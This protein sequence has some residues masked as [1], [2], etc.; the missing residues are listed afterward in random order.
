MDAK[1]VLDTTLKLLKDDH[2]FL[3][4]SNL[5]KFYSQLN[6]GISE[7]YNS[8]ACNGVKSNDTLHELCLNFYGIC[9]NFNSISNVFI[10]LNGMDNKKC[11]D[12][13]Q[14]WLYGKIIDGKYVDSSIKSFL[15]LLESVIKEVH[16]EKGNFKCE[17]KYKVYTLLQLKNK[18]SLHDFVDYYDSVNKAITVDVNKK[19]NEYCNYINKMFDL[20][21]NMLSESTVEKHEEYKDE[22]LMFQKKFD[23]KVLFELK[24]KCPNVCLPF[25]HLT[26]KNSSCSSAH[27]KHEESP[28]HIVGMCKNREGFS[29]LKNDKILLHQGDN[30]KDLKSY[31]IYTELDKEDV[32]PKC[33]QYCNEIFQLETKH[34]GIRK[35]CVQVARNLNNISK[36][37][38][39]KERNK[40]CTYFYYWIYDKLFEMFANN[41]GYIEDMQSARLLLDVSYKI[42]SELRINECYANYEYG[43]NYSKLIE[44][45]ILHDYFEHYEYITNC[46]A[47]SSKHNCET[48]CEYI[49]GI[50]KLYGGYIS[51]CC[52]YF[53]NGGYV[54]RCSDYFKCEEKYNPNKIYVKI[55]CNDKESGKDFNKVDK[56]E[57]IDYYY[58]KMYEKS[59]GKILSRSR[60]TDYSSTSE[61]NDSILK[62]DYF[63]HYVLGSS[64]VLGVF[65]ILFPIYKFTPLG[66]WLHRKL[67]KKKIFENNYNE[68]MNNMVELDSKKVSKNSQY[69]R[70]M[71]IAYQSI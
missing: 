60:K 49:T 7:G 22:L 61:E 51:D 37:T 3:N 9:K 36:K 18:K 16:G 64:A 26:P 31:E 4:D 21:Y 15:E 62:T 53:T 44:M 63:Y 23:E 39:K 10:N 67:Q 65:F 59:K 40:W 46:D 2:I 25:Q 5:H 48:Y 14:Y 17:N 8:N 55:K 1:G 27:A 12:Y 42:N 43:T 66:S 56:P 34:E 54:E 29:S 28:D 47:T 57:A 58:I 33:N 68:D 6:G 41:S 30:L 32:T 11:C 45:K 69:R 13:L 19:K 71:Q 50:N 35:L 52:E 24:G 20:Y 38:E 70:R